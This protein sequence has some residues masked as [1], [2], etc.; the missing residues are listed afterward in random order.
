MAKNYHAFP[1]YGRTGLSQIAGNLYDLPFLVGEH[2]V[3]DSA[4]PF[5]F[6]QH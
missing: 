2:T 1:C 5:H 6:R 3:E 4:K